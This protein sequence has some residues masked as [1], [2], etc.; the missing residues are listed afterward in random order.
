MAAFS[1]DTDAAVTTYTRAWVKPVGANALFPTFMNNTELVLPSV[2]V[3]SQLT[4]IVLQFRTDGLYFG[5][6][7]AATQVNI[8]PHVALTRLSEAEILQRIRSL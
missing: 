8:T 7:T 4:A 3:G 1:F 5:T 2:P 6:Q